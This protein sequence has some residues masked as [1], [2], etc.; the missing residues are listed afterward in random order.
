MDQTVVETTATALDTFAVR[1]ANFGRMMRTQLDRRLRKFGISYVQWSTIRHLTQEG[2]GIVQKQL[3][4]AVGIE[5]PTMV[6]VLDRL[7]GA[8][9]VERREAEH[10]RRYKTVHLTARGR[11]LMDEAEL[12]LAEFR[13]D[14]LQGLPESD[15]EVAARVFDHM[16]RRAEALG[17]GYAGGEPRGPK[18]P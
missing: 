4:G 7:V 8:G 3:A 14:L 10:D 1:L 12:E 15:L 5:G 18:K 17:S 6:G 2:D 16:T 11:A 9:L 13:R